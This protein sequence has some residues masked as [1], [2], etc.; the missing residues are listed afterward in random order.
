MAH[1]LDLRS[2]D[3]I[4]EFLSHDESEH[5]V[6]QALVSMKEFSFSYSV[7]FMLV[8]DVTYANRMEKYWLN[9]ASM[10]PKK[11]YGLQWFQM[12]CMLGVLG[13]ST[14]AVSRALKSA[15]NKDTEAIRMRAL[16]SNRQRKSY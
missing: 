5:E 13:L 16:N 11:S 8:D 14:I 9:A 15:L 12:F 7:K 10:K 2:K 3:K 4:G 1:S 6:P